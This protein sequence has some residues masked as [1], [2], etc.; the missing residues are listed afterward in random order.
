[1][2]HVGHLPGK[3]IVT[4]LHPLRV[5]VACYRAKV[6]FTFTSTVFHFATSTGHVLSRK[7]PKPTHI[8]R[9]VAISVFCDVKPCSLLHRYQHSGGTSC[10]HLRSIRS[11][12][13][14]RYIGTRHQIKRSFT[15]RLCTALPPNPHTALTLPVYSTPLTVSSPPS[16]SLSANIWTWTQNADPNGRAVESMCLRSLACWVCGFD[17]RRG[18]WMSASG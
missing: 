12:W 18:T 7:L 9:S 10:L 15:S 1:M 13:F 8:V 5:F 2:R 14:A 16:L 4:P 17:S 3:S 11:R 6:T